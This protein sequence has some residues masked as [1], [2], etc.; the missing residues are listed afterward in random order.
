MPAN[1]RNWLKQIGLG[2]AA[3]GVAP[4]ESFAITD[5][6]PSNG[7]LLQDETLRLSSNENPYGPSPSAIAAM[8]A[9]LKLSNRYNWNYSS[10]LIKTISEKHRLSQDCVLISAG[11]TVILD[12]QWRYCGSNKGSFVISDITF[13]GWTNTAANNGFRKISVP[14]TANKKQD[15]S[16]ML[17]AIKP[18][19][20]LLY[21]CN[22]NN[23]TG[24][25]IPHNELV[26]FITEASKKLTVVVD[27][28]YLDY[29]D[30]P[31]VASLVSNNKNLIVVKTFSKIYGLAGARIGYALAHPDTIEKMG[32]LQTWNNGDISLTSRVAAIASLKDEPFAKRCAALNREV[33]SATIAQLETL[34]I[35]CIPSNTSFIYF[36]LDQYPKDYFDILKQNKIQGTGMYEANGKWTRITVG[37]ADEMKRFIKTI[38]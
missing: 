11:S 29:T 25:L 7:V 36:S 38:S 23:P 24:T 10:E 4:L 37:T 17:S 34:Q 16:A 32:A 9:A 5:Q 3:I 35:R 15:L 31:S 1:R 13:N 33:R 27:E 22:P 26:A 21:L 6:E 18:D 28:A 30:E 8:T 19:S 14:V 12:L 20:T 2:M